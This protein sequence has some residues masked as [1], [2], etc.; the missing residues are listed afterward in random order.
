MLHAPGLWIAVG[1][2]LGSIPFGLLLSAMNGTDIR[3][4]GSGNIGATNV[5][6][7]GNK[8]LAAATL[9]LDAG[10]GFLAVWL[11]QR[12]GGQD[13]LPTAAGLAAFLGHLF[14][15]WLG[16]RGGKGVATILGVTLGLAW[17]L[18]VAALLVWLIAALVT[19]YSSVGGMLAALVAPLY[20][21]WLVATNPVLT[22]FQATMPVLIMLW[23]A[24][25]LLI[26]KHREN[27]E[28]LRAG[29]ESRIGQKS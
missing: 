8:G 9:I 20:V 19:R 29:T 1:Y 3:T 6:R 11:A 25:F 24:A 4:I 13:W 23:M 10:K 2:L 12:F 14:P 22:M 15:V 18:G 7:S 21:T 27:I 28:R 16:F 17:P 5:L 26:W